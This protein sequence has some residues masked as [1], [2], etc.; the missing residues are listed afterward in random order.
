MGVQDLF[1]DIDL[2]DA[3]ISIRTIKLGV[4][5]RTSVQEITVVY[6]IQKRYQKFIGHDENGKNRF[7]TQTGD[8]MQGEI[9][10]PIQMEEIK[11]HD[12]LVILKKYCE[13][14]ISTLININVDENLLKAEN[15]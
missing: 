6:T 5:P 13:K 15:K 7:I 2:K 11:I 14:K 9:T 1:S 8:V 4:K 10:Y 12:A 3:R